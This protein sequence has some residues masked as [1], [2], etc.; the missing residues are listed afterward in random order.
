MI[1]TQLH[2]RNIGGCSKNKYEP[3]N[4]AS[5]GL[6]SIVVLVPLTHAKTLIPFLVSRLGSN[7]LLQCQHCVS[8]INC[9]IVSGIV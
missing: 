3:S 4:V 9:S 8:M 7:E 5:H 6:N 1:R 2:L